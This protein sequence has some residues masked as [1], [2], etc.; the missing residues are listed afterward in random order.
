M[1]HHRIMLPR[2]QSNNVATYRIPTT[3][4]A[5][6][7]FRR[8]PTHALLRATSSTMEYR[9]DRNNPPIRT[10]CC[11]AQG[12]PPLHAWPILYLVYNVIPQHRELG[13]MLKFVLGVISSAACF[14]LWTNHPELV[15]QGYASAREQLAVAAR[16]ISKATS[17]D[18]RD[19]LW[20]SVSEGPASNSDRHDTSQLSSL[21]HD[22]LWAVMGESNFER[23]A[24]AS[25]ILLKRAK[26]PA[27]A[28]GI[29]VIK[30][31]YFQS[32]QPDDLKTGFS[33][34][35][36]LAYQNVPQDQII[37]QSQRFIERYPRHEACDYAVWSLGELGS[38]EMIPYFFAIIDD[39]Q[40]YGPAARERAFCC[41]SQCGRYTAAQRRQMIPQ[42]I[43]IYGHTHD[44]QTRT[45]TMQALALCAPGSRAQSIDDWRKWWSRQ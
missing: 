14:Y 26:I 1:P 33:Y 24:A 27:S 11:T 38:D 40:K 8:H 4:I 41:L 43:E 22:E 15:R 2:A 19:D 44:A 34:I 13:S 21:S 6:G 7:H 5:I 12:R 18:H 35:G 45:W 32:G 29:P 28:Q 17:P 39:P 25:R 20:D 37:T 42:F 9:Y 36:L 30:D 3:T 31:R 10:S 23:R 16:N